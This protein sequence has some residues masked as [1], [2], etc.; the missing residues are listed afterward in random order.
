MAEVNDDGLEEALTAQSE[1]VAK[2]AANRWFSEANELLLEAGDDHEYDVFPVVQSAQ[3]PQWDSTEQAFVMHWPHTA[4]RFFEHGTT[5]HEVEA[6]QADMLAFEWPEMANEQFGDTG[7]TFKEV[8]SDTWPTVF[9]ESTEPDGIPRIGY[10]RRGR[11]HA[12]RW[13][14]Q[15]EE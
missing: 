5:K 15:Q 14:Q 10:L 8:F 6:Q 7:Q 13:L 1:E 2:E 11:Q 9:F 12:A 4:A 3:P